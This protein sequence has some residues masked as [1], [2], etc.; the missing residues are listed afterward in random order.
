MI[1]VSKKAKAK[2]KTIFEAIAENKEKKRFK[3]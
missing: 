3:K 1:R 2:I